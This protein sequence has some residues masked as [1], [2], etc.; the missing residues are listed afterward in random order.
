MTLGAVYYVMV[1]TLD[2]PHPTRTTAASAHRVIAPRAPS[3]TR[4]RPRRWP[5]AWRRVTASWD[6]LLGCL[7]QPVPD[8][9]M[10]P[11]YGSTNHIIFSGEIR[12]AARRGWP[13]RSNRRLG[14]PSRP[15]REDGWSDHMHN[16]QNVTIEIRGDDLPAARRALRAAPSTGGAGAGAGWGSAA[17]SDCSRRQAPDAALRPRALP[18]PRHLGGAPGA[19]AQCLVNP[20]SVCARDRL[21]E[22]RVARDGDLVRFDSQ[23]GGGY[24]MPRSAIPPPTRRDAVAQKI[25]TPG[26]G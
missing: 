3:C 7:A 4:D 19:R 6:V 10:A 17:S 11:F 12:R 5:A 9:V 15:R 23:G 21:K 2:P 13:S 25:T 22:Q 24:G 20:G 8:K 26:A 1:A 16:V 14:R 18:G